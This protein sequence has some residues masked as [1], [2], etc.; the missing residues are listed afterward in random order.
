MKKQMAWFLSVCMLIMMCA[1]AVPVTADTVYALDT[2]VATE[3]ASDSG[4][5][6]DT[7][8]QLDGNASIGGLGGGARVVFEHVDMGTD[9]ASGLA[10]R[11]DLTNMASLVDTYVINAYVGE[12]K[13]GTMALTGYENWLASRFCAYYLMFDAT[14]TGSDVTLTLEFGP[15]C[16]LGDGQNPSLYDFYVVTTA[17]RDG[18][19]NFPGR[20]IN[21]IH[22]RG[23]NK[24]DG[25]LDWFGADGGTYAI[26]PNITIPHAMDYVVLT[27]AA[28]NL[29]TRETLELEAH[30]N[31]PNGTLLGKVSLADVSDQINSEDATGEVRELVLKIPFD[32]SLEVGTYTI[33]V[34]EKGASAYTHLGRLKLNNAKDP[35]SPIVASYC[36]VEAAGGN[37]DDND[38]NSPYV[39]WFV[40]GNRGYLDLDFGA[41]G[42]D[43]VK[44]RMVR[45]TAG[46]E[47]TQ[48]ITIRKGSSDGEVLATINKA[49]FPMGSWTEVTAQLSEVLTGVQ[50]IFVV[51]EGDSEMNFSR[52]TFIEK[53]ADTK[54]GTETIYAK[55]RDEAYGD[56]P[57][58]T[59]EG[60]ENGETQVVRYFGQASGKAV[61]FERVDFGEME[62]TDVDIT[63]MR[64]G[65]TSGN[66]DINMA[67]YEIREQSASGE[68]LGVLYLRDA[69]ANQFVTLKVDLLKPLTGVHNIYVS[70]NYGSSF[71]SMKFNE[72]TA[73][74]GFIAGTTD[75]SAIKAEGVEGDAAVLT[76]VYKCAGVSDTQ[77]VQVIYAF[78]DNNGRL[79]D[80]VPGE[81]V[82]ADT[83]TQGT[84]K[85]FSTLVPKVSFD[86][87]ASMKAFVWSG[88]GAAEPLTEAVD[89]VQNEA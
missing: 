29:E 13:V 80:I 34:I 42:S 67:A 58:E 1:G 33:C 22:S 31:S 69:P 87:A 43:A 12:D 62:M 39:G 27:Y 18:R 48:L 3:S 60:F 8:T 82:T 6:N 20:S 38:E 32:N 37:K 81:Q 88:M 16:T 85:T 49:D 74:Q 45:A 56:C 66:A 7:G 76:E 73:K 55:D 17:T 40:N 35:Y 79:M 24:E 52:I 19:Y 9:G 4:F 84:A 68:L 59:E 53:G 57:L 14:V 70:S 44:L 26:Y 54:D 71:A 46:T 47:A 28:F 41:N 15:G 89:I 21:T 77:T 5:K 64:W 30:L 83:I 63:L 11:L 2:I 72:G 23:V 65:Y 36:D 51:A 10:L 50:D 25:N 75:L 86:G 78:Y 61:L